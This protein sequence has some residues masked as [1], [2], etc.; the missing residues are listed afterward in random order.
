M[1]SDRK[2]KAKI[3]SETNKDLKRSKQIQCLVDWVQNKYDAINCIEKI[4][5]LEKMIF[6][7]EI[8]KK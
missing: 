3:I 1:S 5:E 6:L 2:I 4:V 7:S 8:V